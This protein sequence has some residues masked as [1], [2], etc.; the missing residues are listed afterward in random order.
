MS[1]LPFF[2]LSS[3]NKG[4]KKKEKKRPGIAGHLLLSPPPPPPPHPHLLAVAGHLLL[5][6]SRR[7]QEKEAELDAARRRTADLE[8][9]LRQASGEAQEWCGLA[10]NNE[11]VSAA[12]PAQI[13]DDDAQSCCF[14]TKV[15]CDG[16]EATSPT[17]KWS[18]KWCGEGDAT[19]LLLPVA[20]TTATP[21]LPSGCTAAT[22]PHR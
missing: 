1:I 21:S 10:R 18:C 19:V 8:E 16:S 4:E 13:A 15:A 20:T 2:L 3:Q 9:R 22:G 5:S 7:L 6:P 12:A 11:A 14:A 17:A